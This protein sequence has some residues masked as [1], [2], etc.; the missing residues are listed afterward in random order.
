MNCKMKTRTVSACLLGFA[1]LFACRPSDNNASDQLPVT[2]EEC[3]AECPVS[4]TVDNKEFKEVYLF[5]AGQSWGQEDPLATFPVKEGRFKDVVLL[6]T[7]LVYEFIFTV[8]GSGMAIVRPFVPTQ[9]GV[10]VFCPEDMY[11]EILLQSSSPENANLMA[12]V[13]IGRNLEPVSAPIYRKFSQ[14]QKDRNLYNEEVYALI[15]EADTAS[16]ERAN[17]LWSQFN[18]MQK[19][20]ASYSVEGLAAK[21]EMDAFQA[22][23]DSLNRDYLVQHPALLSSFYRVWQGIEYAR[24]Q[25][26][27]IQPWMDLYDTC[28]AGRFPGHPYHTEIASLTGNNVGEKIRDF[29]LPDAGGVSHKLSELVAGKMAVVDFWASW[30]G[31]CR[32]RS[33][34][35]KP[36]YEKYAGDDFTIVGVANEYDDDAKWRTALKRDGYPWINLIELEDNPG[37]RCNHA[38]VFLLDRD[39]IILAIDP[40]VEEIEEMLKAVHAK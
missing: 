13:E 6:D 19:L 12:F 17:E 36:I 31:S 39:G 5:R 28:F 3:M 21:R 29:T 37:I 30:C 14:L 23:G 18:K 26:K 20:D 22:W 7:T 2:R 10:S 16:R 24:Q 40:T 25:E 9:T 33:K 38:K 32:I 15:A 11:E 35:L 8:P 34:A 1:M 27:D 4:G